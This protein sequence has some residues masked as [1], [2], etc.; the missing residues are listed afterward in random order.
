MK[1]GELDNGEK[2]EKLRKL[3]DRS[4]NILTVEQQ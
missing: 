4:R 3:L 2:R 1:M